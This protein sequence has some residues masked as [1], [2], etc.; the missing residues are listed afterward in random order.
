M[1]PLPLLLLACAEEPPDPAALD[2]AHYLAALSLGKLEE[3]A[4][5]CRQ[6]QDPA[7]RGDCI[8]G[9]MV[10]VTPRD[11]ALCEELAPEGLWRQEC[12]FAT[13]DDP[14]AELEVRWERCGRAGQFA[15]ACYRHQRLRQSDRL[16]RRV[17]TRLGVDERLDQ[18]DA[19]FALEPPPNAEERE[20]AVR[21][22]WRGY[23]GSHEA[24][25]PTICVEL[26]PTRA[27]DCLDASRRIV[28]ERALQALHERLMEPCEALDHPEQI[29]MLRDGPTLGGDPLVAEWARAA[30]QGRCRR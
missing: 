25:R 13:A 10:Q 26:A 28:E 15:Q 27:T 1:L 11:P 29:P 14:D 30:L 24:V 12:W 21:G 17:R 2:R 22:F 3:G 20:E 9:L 5:E 4:A 19:V 8:S 7:L 6:V 23:H 16:G 18:L